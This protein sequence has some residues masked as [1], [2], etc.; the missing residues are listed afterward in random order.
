MP[1]LSP[2]LLALAV[3]ALA[4][5]ATGG[6]GLADDYIGAEQCKSCHPAEYAQW[7]ATPHARASAALGPDERRDARCT[8]CHA[9]AAEAGLWGVQCESCHGPGRH[10]WPDFIMRDAHLARAAGLQ[11]GAEPSIC[12]GC[13]TAD[14]PRIVPFDTETALDRVRHAVPASP[15]AP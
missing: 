3:L 4:V 8:G 7:K 1:R 10:Y 15:G 9:T 13:H 14:A 5:L 6:A 12:R 2:A 11:S